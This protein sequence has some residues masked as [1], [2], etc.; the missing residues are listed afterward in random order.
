NTTFGSADSDFVT[1]T[2]LDP[3]GSLILTGY[4]AKPTG[5][6]SRT[7]FLI[8]AGDYGSAPPASLVRPVSPTAPLSDTSI[9]KVVDAATGAGI[10]GA[11]VYCNG[12][13]AGTTS[14]SDGTCTW[15]PGDGGSHSLRVTKT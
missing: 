12:K 4:T 6:G 11:T 1:G 13:L 10:A 9:L 5:S 14:E 3:A 8:S 15:Q 7:L 2:V